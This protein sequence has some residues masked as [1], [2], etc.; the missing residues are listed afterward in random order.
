MHLKL[1]HF[2]AINPILYGAMNSRFRE[3]YMV[4]CRKICGDIFMHCIKKSVYKM[5]QCNTFITG[6]C[7][8][9]KPQIQIGQTL[10]SMEDN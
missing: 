6:N 5:M 4:L 7:F 1:L 9:T 10:T 8:T 3:G 2:S